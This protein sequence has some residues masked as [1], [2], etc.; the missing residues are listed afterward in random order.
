[1]EE[2]KKLFD[3]IKK[4]VVSLKELQYIA[5]HEFVSEV[6]YRPADLRYP[7]YPKYIVKYINAD[8]DVIYVKR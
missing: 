4:E 2:T 6:I 5:N 1:M 7:N 8:S 3:I